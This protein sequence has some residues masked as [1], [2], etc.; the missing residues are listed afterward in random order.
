MKGKG[1]NKVWRW[2]S[3]LL[4]VSAWIFFAGMTIKAE[5][6]Y[7]TS[8]TDQLYENAYYL[9]EIYTDNIEELG[10][11]I[12]VNAENRPL[13]DIFKEVAHKAGLGI[14]FNTELDFLN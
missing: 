13:R 1:T 6:Q 12:S 9:V 7:Y 8:N 14:A 2:R 3:Y 11:V 5:A 10:R 4:V